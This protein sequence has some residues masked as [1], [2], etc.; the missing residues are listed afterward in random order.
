MTMNGS[1]NNEGVVRG[2]KGEPWGVEDIGP[3]V[4]RI[5]TQCRALLRQ[6]LERKARQQ[7]F[8]YDK[9][10]IERHLH[11]FDTA[12]ADVK[13]AIADRVKARIVLFI[14]EEIRRV[15]NDAVEDI[16][17]SAESPLLTETV[18]KTQVDERERTY[19]IEDGGN[20][21]KSPNQATPSSKNGTS[22][23]S[24][25]T[26]SVVSSLPP[27]EEAH[28]QRAPDQ[29][30]R[31]GEIPQN[32]A[33]ESADRP[34]DS[35]HPSKEFPQGSTDEVYEGTVKLQIEPNIAFQQVTQ[36]VDALRRRTDL[37][38]LQLVG[39]HKN[40]LR[41]WLGLRTP[42][43]LREALLQIDGVSQVGAD[44]RFE[45]NGDG[46]VLNVRFASGPPPVLGLMLAAGERAGIA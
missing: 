20:H 31:S 5:V 44:S 6:Q 42:L 18:G 16:S 19:P 17:N 12:S 4:D 38:V 9:A 7:S 34:A 1:K 35:A 10:L 37:R 40:G 11:D 8:V 14:Q 24:Q 29:E 32:L 36:F 45:S 2:S 21:V 41:I 28:R 3:T 26:P 33:G 39:S 25:Q 13:S 27:L 30:P 46:S 23:L 22:H 15:L 43:R